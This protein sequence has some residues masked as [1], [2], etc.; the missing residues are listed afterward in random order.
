M[1]ITGSDFYNQILQT[2]I[3][4]DFYSIKM[5]IALVSLEIQIEDQT[6]FKCVAQT[7]KLIKRN[8]LI[9]GGSCRYCGQAS[10]Y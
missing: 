7:I 9:F 10:V 3:I 2:L 8:V 4:T 6:K 1:F 5:R